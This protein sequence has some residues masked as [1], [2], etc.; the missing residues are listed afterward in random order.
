[1]IST[2]EAAQLLTEDPR[3]VQ[4]KAKS[5]EYKSEKLPGVRGAYIFDRAYVERLAERR[6]A[7][8]AA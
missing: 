3:T 1:M 8:V 2:A 6:N 7:R 5:G 4:R